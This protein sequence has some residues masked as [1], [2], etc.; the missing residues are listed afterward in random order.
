MVQDTAR[1]A[2]IT[3]LDELVRVLSDTARYNPLDQDA[4]AAILWPDEIR[5]WETIIP[6]LQARLPVYTLGPYARERMSGPVP[7]L[8]CAVARVLPDANGPTA[9]A[10]PVVY[11]P[12]V[13]AS[14]LCEAERAPDRLV[15]LAE[16]RYRSVTWIQSDGR[17]WT[18][19]RF[20]KSPEIG[21]KVD[22]ASTP[23]TH[24]ALLRTLPLLAE[25]PI[26]WLRERAP[27][28]ARDFDDLLGFHPIQD[29]EQSIHELIT[30][31]ESAEL[32][33]KSTARWNVKAGIFDAKM[34]QEISKS[35]CA[36]LNSRHGGTL[37]IGVA[38]DGS[39]H[40]LED[41][42]RKWDKS[43]TQNRSY[44]RD[45]FELWLMGSLLLDMFGRAFAPYIRITFHEVD[46]KDVCKVAVAPAPWPAFAKEGKEE[47]FFMR[48]GNQSPSL[49]I[50]E[51]VKYIRDRW[52]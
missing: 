14:Q 52:G 3:F 10:I 43:L 44:L 45:K 7:W 17:D 29:A 8:R 36:L 38:D 34:E 32:E 13:S 22:V 33:F 51:A 48:T 19:T 40:G 30:R 1:Y 16:L 49:S 4:P 24:A 12:G 46:G 27:W 15:L 11:L 31:G 23:D 20:M 2:P 41:D 26:T 35:V 42:Y 28:K 9:D 18:V 21:L 50:S 5:D 37:L 39:I 47:R 25:K 6:S